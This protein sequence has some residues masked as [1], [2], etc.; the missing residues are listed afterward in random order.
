MDMNYMLRVG[1]QKEKQTDKDRAASPRSTEPLL[2]SPTSTQALCS[3][4]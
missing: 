4:V 3:A 1:W 2:F